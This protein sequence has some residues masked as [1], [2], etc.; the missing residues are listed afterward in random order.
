MSGAPG[1]TSTLWTAP[2]F[3]GQSQLVG[4]RRDLSREL[5][6]P[7]THPVPV[8]RPGEEADGHPV[9]P[10]VDARVAVIDAGQLG[11]RLHQASALR[12]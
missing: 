2:G 3:R 5:Q 10:D 1:T 11:D 12:E 7:S 4:R 8:G 9:V 6:V